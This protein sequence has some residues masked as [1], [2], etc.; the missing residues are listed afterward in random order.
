MPLVLHQFMR[1][2][3]R[4][5]ED[6]MVSN[7]HQSSAPMHINEDVIEESLGLYKKSQKLVE[8]AKAFSEAEAVE[9][10]LA[11]IFELTVR[12]WID[13]TALKTRM[14]ADQ[15]LS[16]D[17]FEP[18][19]ENGPSSSVTD[20]FDSFRSAS[21]FLMDLNWP[22]EQQLAVFA[23]RLAKIFSLSIN[24]YCN[25]MEQ[26]FAR[27]MMQG[28]VVQPAQTAAKQKAWIEKAKSTIASLQG[29]KKIQAF[30]NFTPAVGH[31]FSA[32]VELTCSLA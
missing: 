32:S 3:I 8:R 27:D 26:L 16:V 28:E 21:T 6:A 17:T 22:D 30:F 12:Q 18:T 4:D 29:E 19:T 23:T 13:Q 15:A 11:P 10:P 1:L 7:P 9:Y 31:S 24:D 14:W 5:L 25:K 20:L 2:W